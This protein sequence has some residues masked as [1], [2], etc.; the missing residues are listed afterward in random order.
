MTDPLSLRREELLARCAEQRVELALDLQA[1]RA[2]AEGGRPFA[3]GAAAL[4]GARVLA[5]PRL[6]VAA[7]LALAF[8]RP[9]RLLRV[10]RFAAS[11][12][13]IARGG[14]GLVARFRQ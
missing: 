5:H 7:A 6:A 4:L 2:P 1:L 12:W 13:R 14:L 3:A 10:T 11:G 9:A 8:I